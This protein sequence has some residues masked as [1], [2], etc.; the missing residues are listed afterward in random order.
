MRDVQRS[1]TTVV[2]VH[3]MNGR[4]FKITQIMQKGGKYDRRSDE[5]RGV[6][7]FLKVY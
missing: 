1:Q 7:A 6:D 3:K 2:S 4:S 5:Y